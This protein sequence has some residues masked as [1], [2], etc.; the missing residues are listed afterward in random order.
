MYTIR[1]N[2]A[3]PTRIRHFKTHVR[4]RTANSFNVIKM[5]NRI[6]GMAQYKN[7]YDN[8]N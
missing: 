8:I 5:E 1:R 7:S 4:L 2:S 6:S 3:S